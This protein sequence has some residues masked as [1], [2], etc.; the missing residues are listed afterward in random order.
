MPSQLPRQPATDWGKA[1]SGGQANRELA[2]SLALLPTPE[3]NRVVLLLNGYR[4]QGIQIV[5]PGRGRVVQTLSSRPRS[6]ARASIMPGAPLRFRWNQDVGVSLCLERR[7]KRRS[8]ISLS[9]HS[10]PRRGGTRYPAG[11]RLAG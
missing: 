7:P 10:A 2:S 8:R 11:L 6:S 5:E 3:G 1:R 4:E 9:S